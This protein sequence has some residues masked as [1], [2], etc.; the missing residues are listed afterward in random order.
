MIAPPRPASNHDSEQS[1]ARGQRLSQLIRLL[2]LLT[3]VGLLGGCVWAPSGPFTLK[4]D[5]GGEAGQSPLPKNGG[6]MP[7]I[8][9]QDPVTSLSGA[10]TVAPPPDLWTRLRA[11][12]RLQKIDHPRVARELAQLLRHPKSLQVLMQRAVPY[13][14]HI[15]EQLEQRGLPGELA[16]L[17]AVESGFKPQV[18]SGN[19][20]AGLWQFMPATGRMLGLR[21]DR[22]YDARR[23]I[24]A[25]TDAALRYLVRLQ[26]R[27]DGDLLHALA[28]Y[29][30]GI[31]TVKRAIRKA[32]R[33]HRSTR[34]W[35]LD[36][37]GETD[38][39]VPRLLAIARIVADP[40]RYG[41]KLPKAANAPF[42]EPTLVDGTL[43]LGLA[44]E[45]A[46]LP[47]DEFL[48]LNPG[49]R[50][51]I[52]LANGRSRLLLPITHRERFEQNLA[53]IP[54]DKWQRWADH[55]VHSG[56]TLIAIARRYQVSVAAIR[57]ANGIHGHRI[58]AGQHLR[59]PL[60][61]Q[62]SDRARAI[63]ATRP[64]LRY[65]VR[66]GDSLYT[67]ARRFSVSVSDLKR[68][69]RVGR[70]IRPGQRLTVYLS[71]TG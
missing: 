15:T 24:Q 25:S 29:N 5:N 16:L 13:L 67:I 62:A 53:K 71:S 12:F 6:N 32:K 26:N 40:E 9:R 4:P 59:I 8:T 20:A 50:Q 51:G 37:P 44:A 36:L 54:R 10:V 11:D 55:R 19:G 39:Y 52:T 14:Y 17:P 63:V 43:D 31:G 23:D 18:Y 41:V 47:L 7:T 35:N 46:G 22:L 60:S 66:K 28:A 38:A 61:G 64:K 1:P 30:C 2:S 49:Y 57:E 68:W 27:L 70:Y 21:Q 56:D 42:F 33:Q 69:N 45:L 58:R 34:Y 65:H 48:A 3:L